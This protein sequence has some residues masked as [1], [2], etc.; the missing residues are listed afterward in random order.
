MLRCFPIHFLLVLNFSTMLLLSQIAK[1]FSIIATD[2]PL[3]L[4]H[5]QPFYTKP[6]SYKALPIV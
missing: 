6:K 4:A 1:V 2:L 3:I 5:H